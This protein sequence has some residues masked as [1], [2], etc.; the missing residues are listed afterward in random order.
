MKLTR[1][2]KRG[3]SR[4]FKWYS[5]DTKRLYSNVIE[6]FTNVIK[7]IIDNFSNKGLE[8]NQLSEYFKIR[9]MDSKDLFDLKEGVYMCVWVCVN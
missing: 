3:T 5:T 1:E 2:N 7:R 6:E 8:V 4:P 9:E